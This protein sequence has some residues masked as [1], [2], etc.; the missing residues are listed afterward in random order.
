MKFEAITA[1]RIC[2]SRSLDTVFD[3]GC[4][5]SCGVFPAADEPTPA[6]MPLELVQCA[7]CGLVQLRHNFQRDD[8]FRHTYGYRSGI[9]ES[10]KAHLGS[11]VAAIERRVALRSGDIVLDIGS[12]DGTTLGLYKTAGLVRVGI[13]PTIER[14]LQYYQPGILTVADF[15]TRDNY[16]KLKLGGLAKV[17][18]SIAMF[19]DLPDPNAFVADVRDVLA[20]DGIW[21]LE[22]SYLPTMIDMGSFDTICHEH[23]EYYGLRQIVLLGERNGLRVID[24]A[25]NDAN[26][27]SFQITMCHD[28]QVYPRND[29]AINALLDREKAEGYD[30]RRPIDKLREQIATARDSVMTFLAG[31]KRDGKLVHG[32]GASTKG[33]TLLQYFW[34]TADLLPAIADRNPTKFGCRT[35]GT[36]IPIVSEDESRAMRPDSYFVLPWHFRDGFIAREAQFLG[37]CGKLVFPLPKFEIAGQGRTSPATMGNR[38]APSS[39]ARLGRMAATSASILPALAMPRSASGAIMSRSARRGG[40]SRSSIRPRFSICSGPSSPT[41]STISPRIIIRRKKAR[42]ACASSSTRAT[43]CTAAAC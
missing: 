3:L 13:D 23:L 42:K 10:M 32:Y 21:V 11:I 15:F 31:A 16:R 33:N 12:N 24:V 39:S 19:Y 2:G 9:N 5:V 37:R 40:R 20:P 36:D 28:N 22:Q 14:F 43:P 4:L 34:V 18:T 41:R 27:G 6:P 26:G 7:G 38:A 35:P 8:L 30:G 1:C 17:V 29:K 25:L